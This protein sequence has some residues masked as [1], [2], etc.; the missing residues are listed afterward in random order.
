M[1]VSSALLENALTHH[2]FTSQNG[3]EPASQRLEL[4]GDSVLGLVVTDTLFRTY[5]NLAETVLARQRAAMVN[6]HALAG[7]ARGLH[8]GRYLKL[9]KDE[10]ERGGRDEPAI[11]ADALEAVIGAVY[12]DAGLIAASQL[13][14]RLFDPLLTPIPHASTAAAETS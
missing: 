11:L 3:G 13:T 5:P 14:R 4:L 6:M 8:L 7:I 1:K 9:G 2:S 10:E 12:L